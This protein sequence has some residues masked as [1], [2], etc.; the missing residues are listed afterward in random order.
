MTTTT[1]ASGSCG[2]V[3]AE[4]EAS[5]AVQ[6]AS[7]ANS[8][9]DWRSVPRDGAPIPTTDTATSANVDERPP[10]DSVPADTGSSLKTCTQ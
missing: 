9:R 10:L 6:A 5:T 8:S 1:R 4:V 2:Q 3:P 7:R